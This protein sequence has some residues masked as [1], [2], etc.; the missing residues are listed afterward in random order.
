[1]STPDIEKSRRELIVVDD[2][3]DITEPVRVAASTQGFD[4]VFTTNFHE[5]VE[6]CRN[7]T[8]AILVSLRVGETDGVEILRFLSSERCQ[9]T[10]ILAG[11]VSPRVMK[12]ALRLARAYR[13]RVA[14]TLVKPFDAGDLLALLEQIDDIDRDPTLKRPA[15]I[16][17]DDMLDA[18][19]REEFDVVY[20]PKIRT[21]SLEFVGVEALVRWQHPH[22]GELPPDT[23][24]ALA[25]RT[26]LIDR[27]TELVLDMAFSQ[28]AQW[29]RNGLTVKLAVNISA[30]SLS[31]MD[32]PDRIEQIASRH[33][34]PCN[35]VVLEIT[36]SWLGQ[37]TITALDILTRLRMKGFELSVDDFGTGYATMLQ[38][39]Q[40][41]YS[42]IKLDQA[43]IRD[44]ATDRE[45][46]SIVEA[47]IALGQKLGLC[48]VAEGIEKQADWD[49][50]AELGCDE[51]QGF[52]IARPMPGEA[53]PD[54]LE[55][56]N[57]TLGH[58][59]DTVI[60]A[61]LQV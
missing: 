58:N 46:R 56:W 61:Q 39:K 16:G 37:D 27:I 19:R 3:P 47:A 29:N 26:G 54:W 51:G 45:S 48:V 57:E 22:L 34:V 43:F 5:F 4:P 11:A 35:K 13:L 42:E 44:A 38:L 14:G 50:I 53:I 21:R 33:R 7:D 2:D 55:H 15:L 12:A 25:E 28:W 30:R 17:S 20:Q 1:M 41:P 49:L 59:A 31:E 6:R 18:V 60:T 52:Y 32:L 10:V 23:F 9:A 36:E 40:I 8:T 24:I